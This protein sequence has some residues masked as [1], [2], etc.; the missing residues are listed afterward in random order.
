MD[1]IFI[2]FPRITWINVIPQYLDYI[3]IFFIPL[4][5]DLVTSFQCFGAEMDW[6]LVGGE[7]KKE[8]KSPNFISVDMWR[9]IKTDN[10]KSLD[11][12]T[13]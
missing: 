6:H 13:I 2:N 5:G 1:T 7:K 8:T 4:S 10:K 12:F 9:H 3:Y 11:Y